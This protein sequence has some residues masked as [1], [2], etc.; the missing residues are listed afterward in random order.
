[1][2]GCR[3]LPAVTRPTSEKRVDGTVLLLAGLAWATGIIH[4]EA[5]VGHTKESRLYVVLFVL[6]AIAQFAWGVF[7]FRSP[8]PALLVAGAVVSLGVVVFW[9]LSRTT[10]VPFGPEPWKPEEVGPFDLI[11]TADEVMLAFLVGS[12]FWRR[13]PR[14]LGATAGAAALALL[15]LSS[16]SIAGG[17]GH[18]H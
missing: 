9:A 7:I 10:G 17:S 4:V 15:L 16:L 6:L 13:A 5:A 11:A 1:M 3:P 12:R 14:A 18:I 8:A 2:A